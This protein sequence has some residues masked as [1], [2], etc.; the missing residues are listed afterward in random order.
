MTV[1]RSLGV[2]LGA[3][4]FLVP[5]LSSWAADAASACLPQVSL[6]LTVRMPAGEP[7]AALLESGLETPLTLLDAATGRVLWS[8]GSET[9]A[10]QRFAGMDAGFA[11]SLVAVDLD[12]DGVHDRLYAGDLAARLW[13]FDLQQGDVPAR[14]ATGGILADFSNDEGRAFLA[15]PD[16]SLVAPAGAGLALHIAIGTAAPGNP[17]ASNRFYVL[18][19]HA[20][21]TAW[22]EDEYESWQ[23]L[24][25]EDLI[26]VP[27]TVDASEGA[28]AIDPAGPGWYIELGQGHV[29]GRSL[30]MDGRT[31]LVVATALPRSGPCEVFA[32][33]ATLDLIRQR[34]LPAVAEP[35]DWLA[36][37][38]AT[39]ALPARFE[40]VLSADGS[41][42]LCTLS[43]QAVSACDLDTRPRKSW[44]L[45]TDA[46]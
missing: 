24:R 14:W 37:L 33:I 22:T 41:T 27:A 28:D 6:P 17:R 15:Q 46:Q 39:L 12:S 29:V 5:S 19:D 3:L 26:R 31:V 13:R 2:M 32:R 7:T 38:P 43:G 40:H 25:E 8:A 23:P 18:R 45:R 36:P 10:L 16:V 1:A 35:D 21:A 44:W 34:L 4:S 30:T 11:G 42:A 9:S 20:F